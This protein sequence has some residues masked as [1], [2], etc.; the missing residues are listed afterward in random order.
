MDSS[1]QAIVTQL[2]SLKWPTAPQK[3]SEEP[4]NK[5]GEKTGQPQEQTEPAAG[6][7]P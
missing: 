2:E 4:V 1:G 7:A 3:P 6:K 5:T